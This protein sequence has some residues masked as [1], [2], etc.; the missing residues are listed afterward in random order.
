[1]YTIYFVPVSIGS[2][3]VG[4]INLHTIQ[5]FLDMVITCIDV[6]LIRIYFCRFYKGHIKVNY[7]QL[8]TNFQ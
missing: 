5:F 6:V 3:W 8:I 1:M 7:N 4:V 2:L